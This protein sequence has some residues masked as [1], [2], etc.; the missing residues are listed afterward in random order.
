MSEN[1][2][3]YN[4]E[5]DDILVDENIIEDEAVEV[6][7]QVQNNNRHNNRNRNRNRNRHNNNNNHYN[8]N[9]NDYEYMMTFKKWF[10]QMNTIPKAIFKLT[11][12]WFILFTV[13][14]L[15]SC[16]TRE[17][18][19]YNYET[20]CSGGEYDGTTLSSGFLNFVTNKFW[21][22]DDHSCDQYRRWTKTAERF[23][24]IKDAGLSR[25]IPT[26][27]AT[28]TIL[29]AFAYILKQI[30]GNLGNGNNNF[31]NNKRNFNNRRN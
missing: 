18:L 29:P 6:N 24:P 3:I 8:H 23:C 21:Y 16:P 27:L 28:A 9:H 31:G 30:F 1:D 4:A 13:V 12:M 22:G 26:M 7:D 17:W 20:F 14:T 2:E 25:E 19:R 10:P 11:Q 5:N 15:V